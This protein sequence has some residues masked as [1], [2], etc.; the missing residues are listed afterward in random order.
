[1]TARTVTF[2][3]PTGSALDPLV[4]EVTWQAWEM[5][6]ADPSRLSEA[7]M[8]N[9]NIG[10]D[11][12]V[13]ALWR[14]GRAV[15][16]SEVAWDPNG[17]DGAGSLA[18]RLAIGVLGPSNS[19]ACDANGLVPRVEAAVA[20]AGLFS[21]RQIDPAELVPECAPGLATVNLGAHAAHVVQG[22]WAVGDEDD[23]VEV[24][25]RFSTTVEPWFGV[26]DQIVRSGRPVRVRATV[27]ATE[28]SPADRLE[29]D[30]GLGRVRAIRDRNDRRP[31]IQF[32]A[33][34]AEATLLDLRASLASPVLAGELA[35]CSPEPLPDTLLRSLA[36]SFTSESD[37]LRQQGRVVVASNRLVLG[38]FEIRRNP[39]G[40]LDAQR[41]GVPLRGGLQPRDLRDLLTL[42]E[43]PIGWPIPFHGPLLS[44][45]TLIAVD[46]P[47]P[48]ILRPSNAVE[49][50]SLGRTPAGRPLVLPLDLRTRHL[51]ATGTWG[52]GKST[53]L[54]ALA[55][56]DLRAG[57][58]FVFLDPHGTAA[59]GLIA[60][61][62]HLGID[63]V[64]LDGADGATARLRTLP[65]LGRGRRSRTAVDSAVRRVAD[66]VASSL[67]NPD[68]TGPRWY[69]AFEALLELV[70]V[71]EGE[72]LD[73]AVWLN[74]PS[75]LRSRLDHS[76]LSALA[77][78]TLSN[79]LASTGDGGDVRG[80]VSSKL[81]PV[82]GSGVR[83]VIAPVGRGVDVGTALAEG[84]PVIV[85]LADLSTSE[86]N[87]VGHLV[88]SAVIDAAL[89]RSADRRDLVT[90][91]VDEAHRFPA[92][93]LSRVI[94]E[95]RKF[96]VALA[97]ATQSLGQLPG[98]LADLALGAG[99]QV[100][101]RATPDTA[102]K[103]S[104]VLGVPIRD[105][106]TMADLHAVVLVQGHHPTTVVVPPY[107]TCPVPR[108]LKP[109]REARPPRRREPP[110]RVAAI[111]FGAT[112]PPP[113]P[114]SKSSA[115]PSFVDDFILRRRGQA[116]GGTAR[117][118]RS[119]G[120]DM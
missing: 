61:A 62:R 2:A 41:R 33:D 5:T 97:L 98:E 60:F 120:T 63:P 42:T 108:E 49:S 29:L 27:L 88:L 9:V 86:A 20:G 56:D 105:L 23:L 71:H 16:M 4:E 15:A 37:V 52:A 106:V 101:F 81:H 75:A 59:D 12:L 96:G 31:E 47:V 10:F 7:V 68:W 67:P 107:E 69:A 87:L 51:V 104:P 94:A 39:E 17:D 116:T 19:T 64:V 103:L 53:L 102:A 70:V 112:T 77:R 28:L 89:A 54:F 18:V 48:P 24:V 95:G 119:A 72:L 114:P 35:L 44:I 21:A 38:G 76:D 32:D 3:A 26:V 85:S 14:P 73:A 78:S 1:M 91:Y 74:D 55:L 13:E 50:T 8:Q 25:S 111:P 45:P 6:A 100:A 43:S 36:A 109:P 83:R 99:T 117:P 90:C 40:W 93:G 11:C 30:S 115:S 113:P 22:L 46:R 80:W 92:R 57:R 110:C 82:V 84:R 34:R 58:P 118:G 79:L 66:A 65:R